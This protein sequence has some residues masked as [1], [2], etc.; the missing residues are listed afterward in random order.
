V[1]FLGYFFLY[2]LKEGQFQVTWNKKNL[3]E[4]PPYYI[5]TLASRSIGL[6]YGTMLFIIYANAGLYTIVGIEWCGHIFLCLET[7][8]LSWGARVEHLPHTNGM[9]KQ[10]CHSSTGR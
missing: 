5:D 1:V 10:L 3:I 7:S 9:Q 6:C 2:L 8:L 4:I